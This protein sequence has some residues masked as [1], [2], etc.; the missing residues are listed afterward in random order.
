MSKGYHALGGIVGDRRGY[1]DEN[2]TGV[3]T[4]G[5][6]FMLKLNKGVKFKDQEA[7]ACSC[8]NE[9]QSTKCYVN[10]HEFSC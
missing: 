6:N 3:S 7:Q 1:K 2:C 8:S 5:G 4:G 9:T 10:T